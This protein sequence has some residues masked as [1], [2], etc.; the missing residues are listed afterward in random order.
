MVAPPVSG[1]TQ[2]MVRVSRPVP[3]PA[4]RVAAPHIDGQTGVLATPRLRPLAQPR[5]PVG[6]PMPPTPAGHQAQGRVAAPTAHGREAA[7]QRPPLRAPLQPPQ[8]SPARAVSLHGRSKTRCP[9]PPWATV[10]GPQHGTAVRPVA[11]PVPVAL[12][13]AVPTPAPP[14][15]GV[16]ARRTT[17]RGQ[18]A[19][20]QGSSISAQLP[21]AA[22]APFGLPHLLPLDLT[23]SIA[24]S[25]RTRTTRPL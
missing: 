20:L 1:L 14:N 15:D 10:P 23:P 13:A 25:A 21:L 16:S 8:A 2:Q 7:V 19:L 24:P 11:T 18:V 3:R 6:A 12:L 9:P 17:T 5:R 22:L 4:Q